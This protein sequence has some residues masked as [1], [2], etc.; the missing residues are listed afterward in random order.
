MQMEIPKGGDRPTGRIHGLDE[1]HR[2]LVDLF[3]RIASACEND[4]AVASVRERI[5]TFLIYAR[6]HFAGEEECMFES[7][8]PGYVEHRSDHARL[9]QD[10]EDF[11]ATLGNALEPEDSR[12]IV[13]YFSYWLTRHMAQKDEQFR[14]FLNAKMYTPHPEA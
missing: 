11:V 2:E 7:H 1:A 13:R 3:K 12:A 10:A 4:A 8:Y 5:R 9:L 6:W 14:V